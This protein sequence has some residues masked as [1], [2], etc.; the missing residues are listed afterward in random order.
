MTCLSPPLLLT[1]TEGRK[2]REKKEEEERGGKRGRRGIVV[3]REG[4]EE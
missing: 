1:H 3:G 2:E 4:E